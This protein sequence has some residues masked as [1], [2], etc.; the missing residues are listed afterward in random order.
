[1]CSLFLR[2]G[3]TI[4]CQVTERR[5]FSADLP[6]GS[7]EIPCMLTFMGDPNEV[8]NA[9]KL[10]TLN[11]ATVVVQKNPVDL[12]SEEIQQPRRKLK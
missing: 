11:T 7:L 6:Q 9:R 1:M 4:Q 2:K 5:H 10:L 12:D 3:G 8:A